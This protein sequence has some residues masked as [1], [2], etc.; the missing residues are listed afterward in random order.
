MIGIE[1]ALREKRGVIFEMAERGI[2]VVHL[3]YIKGLVQ[4]YGL[5]WDPVPLPDPGKG[6]VYQLAREKQP[7]FLLFTAGYFLLTGF[8]L[9]FRKRLGLRFYPLRSEN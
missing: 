8:I 1:K 7:G 3:L 2:P 6:R 5:S 4:R 9:V